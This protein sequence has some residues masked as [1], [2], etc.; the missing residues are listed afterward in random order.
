MGYVITNNLVDFCSDAYHDADPENC[1][2]K[3]PVQVR[4]IVRILL[5]T[6]EVDE[7]L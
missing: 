3:L 7:Y 1:R 4:A 6:Q 5:T 2:N